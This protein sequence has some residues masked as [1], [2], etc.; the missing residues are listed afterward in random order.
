MATRASAPPA[1]D[2]ASATVSALI[3]VWE[4]VLGRSPISACDRFEE[5]AGGFFDAI[6]LIEAVHDEFGAKLPATAVYT[7]PT[8]A[9]MA[10]ILNE[11]EKHWSPL[12]LIRAGGDAPPGVIAP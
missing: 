1:G 12:L 11:P 10:Q 6:R 5:M 7:A 3:Q 2:A 9:L 8:P 4:R